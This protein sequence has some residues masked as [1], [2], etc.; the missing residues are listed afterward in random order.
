MKLKLVL[1]TL[2][3]FGSPL[4][5][6]EGSMTTPA[7]STC[8]MYQLEVSQTLGLTED[9]CGRIS[10]A[11]SAVQP[12]LEELYK[13]L[14]PL[15]AE[16]TNL[17][18]TT[19]ATNEEVEVVLRQSNDVNRKRLPV[20]VKIKL[21][22]DERNRKSLEV[23]NVKQRQLLAEIDSQAKLVQRFQIFSNTGLTN[24]YNDPV[25]IGNQAKGSAEGRF[26]Q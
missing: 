10:L 20:R 2:A 13:E 25:F 1:F 9:Q 15:D 12:S 16:A 8:W 18:W 14:A 7:P 3:L 19:P 5:A 4:F 23:L 24:G 22:M 21:I 26:R 11:W 17:H 6:Q